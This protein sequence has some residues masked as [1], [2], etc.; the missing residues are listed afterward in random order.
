MATTRK[1]FAVC[2]R[3]DGYP[4][5][6]ELRK[7]YEVLADPDAAKHDQLR[8]ID[9]SGEDYL[10]PVGYFAPIELTPSLRRAVLAAE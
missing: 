8:V 2:V 3:N 6:L 7:I 10:Y 4:A 1:A 5:S 9:E